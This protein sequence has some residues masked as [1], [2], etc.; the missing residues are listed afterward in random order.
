MYS[1]SL[2][3]TSAS[4]SSLASGDARVG[5][6]GGGEKEEPV[7]WLPALVWRVDWGD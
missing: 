6:G 1:D 2:S 5:A 3:G 4:L 7:S